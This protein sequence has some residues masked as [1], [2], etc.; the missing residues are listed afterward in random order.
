MTRE[1]YP[2][3]LCL[4]A[5]VMTSLGLTAAALGI[6]WGAAPASG[7]A[8]RNAWLY[9]HLMAAFTWL[10]VCPAAA[11]RPSQGPF[12]SRS[13]LLWQFAALWTGMIPAL[14][15]ATLLTSPGAPL[16]AST[17]ALQIALS[18]FVMGTLA[19]SGRFASP[20]LHVLLATLLVILAV[21]GPIAAFLIAEFHPRTSTAWQQVL[22]PLALA[23]ATPTAGTWLLAAAYGVLGGAMLALA[24]VRRTRVAVTP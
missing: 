20:T 17:I 14:A 9:V 7:D 15:T 6:K 5:I 8:L 16:F 3:G 21:I 1:R 2:L 19:L 12:L 10:L 11:L 23:R 24:G 4:A 13:N 18:L 22:P